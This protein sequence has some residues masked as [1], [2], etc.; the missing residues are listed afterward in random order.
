MRR[1]TD[2]AR[3][4]AKRK[5]A[6]EKDENKLMHVW[7]ALTKEDGWFHACWPRSYQLAFQSPLLAVFQG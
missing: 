6:S 5:E 1:R 4:E 7:L 3:K 2:K